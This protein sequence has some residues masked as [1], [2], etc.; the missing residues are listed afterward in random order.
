MKRCRPALFV[1]LLLNAA[2]TGLSPLQASPESQTGVSVELP[3]IDYPFNWNDGY[4]FPSMQQSLKLSKGFYDVTHYG[5]TQYFARQPKKALWSTL[6]L[7]V[8]SLWLP[9]GSGW[10]HEEWHRAVMSN[11][12][13][14]S[15]DEIYKFNLFSETTSVSHVSD[16]DLI[17]LKQLYPADMVRLS[18]AGMEA[19]NE[20]NVALEQDIFFHGRRYFVD[21]LMWLNN[22]NNSAY[23]YTCASNDANR[24]TQDLLNNEGSDIATRDF[25]GLDCTAWVYDLFRPSEPYSARGLHPSGTGIKRYIQYDDLTDAEKEFVHKQL[26]LSFLNLVNP[27]LYHHDWFTGTNPFNGR[28]MQW[29]AALRHY[30]TSFGYSIDV[31]LLAQQAQHKL[32]LTLHNYFNHHHYFPGISLSLLRYPIMAGDQYIRFTPRMDVWLQPEDQQ[33][34]TRKG[35]VGGLVSLKLERPL[36]ERYDGFVELE[37]KTDGWVAGNVYLEDNVSVRLGFIAHLN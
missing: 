16:A 24:L 21:A 23:L 17:R 8:L 35:K 3:I 12:G 7:D 18:A 32:T 27:I 4:R 6:G 22:L 34:D 10:L 29:N 15:Y 28:P 19:Q 30:L 5:I 9:F 1:I 36:S 31:N 11:R 14:D 2:G 13:I 33:F 25:T 37:A 20:L 26:A